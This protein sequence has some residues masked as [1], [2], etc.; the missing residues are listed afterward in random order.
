MSN[1]RIQGLTPRQR[2]IADLL[3]LTEDHRQVERLCSQDRDARV[4]RELIVAAE[5]DQYQEIHRDVQDLISDI[6]R[7]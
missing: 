4:V 6:S 5:L 3:W 7:G 2:L 1:I